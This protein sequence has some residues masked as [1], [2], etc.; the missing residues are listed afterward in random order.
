MLDDP[1]INWINA[2]FGSIGIKFWL[3]LRKKIVNF[4]VKRGICLLGSLTIYRTEVMPEI[5]TA[6][7]HLRRI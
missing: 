6:F 5:I 7:S 2:G 3:H 4:Q 1:A